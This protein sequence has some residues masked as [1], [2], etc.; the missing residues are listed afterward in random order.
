M[1]NILAVASMFVV[2][3]PVGVKFGKEN[4]SPEILFA[5][6]ISISL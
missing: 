6:E 4:T 1:L 2:N 3:I 5:K